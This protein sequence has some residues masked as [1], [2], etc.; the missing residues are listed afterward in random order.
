MHKSFER[1]HCAAKFY[2][3]FFPGK[4]HNIQY[5]EINWLM[6]LSSIYDRRFYVNKDNVKIC[7][8][9]GTINCIFSVFSH[10]NFESRGD[11][12]IIEWTLGM[13]RSSS[14][15]K[16]D[17]KKEEVSFHPGAFPWS[18]LS[19]CWIHLFLSPIS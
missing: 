8:S 13:T 6:Y 14:T 3:L 1:K 15:T 9:T 4:E 17:K 5:H 19:L 16:A 18:L 11:V 2:F 10:F 7:S 12:K